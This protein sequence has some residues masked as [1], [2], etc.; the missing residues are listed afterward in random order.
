M[1]SSDCGGGKGSIFISMEFRAICSS[2]K[3]NGYVKAKNV[4]AFRF[5]DVRYLKLNVKVLSSV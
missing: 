1:S 4:V 3:E 2:A 5:S